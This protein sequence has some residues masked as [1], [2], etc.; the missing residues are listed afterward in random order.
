MPLAKIAVCKKCKGSLSISTSNRKGLSVNVNIRCNNWKYSVSDHN[1][2]KILLCNGKS[3]INTRLAYEF[4]SIGKAEQ[5]AKT[6]YA[7]MNLPK[8]PAF[9]YYTKILSKAAKEVC[10][11]SMKKAAQETIELNDG[12]TDITTLF[13]RS[14]QKRGHSSLNGIVS[15]ISADNGK[16]IDIRILSKYCRCKQRLEQSH[17][18]KCVANY[19]GEMEKWKS[20]VSWI[21]SET[22]WSF[23][24]FAI[25]FI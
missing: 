10:L 14:W 5:A 21:C 18:D 20:K 22:R 13:Y 9:K 2:N 16:V 3:E 6:V 11:D 1:S 15:R 23:T 8:P 24:A 7:I 4:R 25:S 19:G 12:N 17:E